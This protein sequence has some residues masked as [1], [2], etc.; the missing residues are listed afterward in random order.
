MI[1]N[2]IIFA[3]YIFLPHT[4]KFDI[5]YTLLL[6]IRISYQ[7]RCGCEWVAICGC[8]CSAYADIRPIASMNYET[9]NE[10]AHNS[11][12]PRVHTAH[13]CVIIISEWIIATK[14]TVLKINTLFIICMSMVSYLWIMIYILYI[15]LKFWCFLNSNILSI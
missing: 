3:Y 4:V 14:K 9:A 2:Y 11:L 1:Y 6:D 5:F 8:G 7:C 13:W 10:P 15:L 12:P